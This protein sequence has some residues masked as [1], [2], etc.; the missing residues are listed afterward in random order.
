M[1]LAVGGFF[2]YRAI[3][4]HF[5]PPD[6]SS[7]GTG[8]V[9]VQIRP[10]DTATTVG[11]RLFALGVV[12]STRAFVN[13][14]EHSQKASALQ[15]G[16]YRLHKHMKATLAFSLLLKPSSRIQVKVT[17]PEGWRESQITAALGQ[18]SGIPLSDYKQALRN[19]SR[20]RPAVLRARQSRGVPVP[21]DLRDP[22]GH[23]RDRRVPADGEGL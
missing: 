13:A 15:P 7:A 21:R 19:T 11:D 1:P 4:A 5:F 2:A 8:H 14:A 16:F 17:I 6:Y 3:S 23:D 10:G 9:T 20:A 12:A 22:A 18:N